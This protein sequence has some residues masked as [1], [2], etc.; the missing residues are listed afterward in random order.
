[1]LFPKYYLLLY[2]PYNIDFGDL[3]DKSSKL[4][5]E[6]NNNK[7]GLVIDVNDVIIMRDKKI[8][9]V[10]CYKSI[11][12]KNDGVAIVKDIRYHNKINYCNFTI[13][14]R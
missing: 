7:V 5:K 1:M 3:Y 11:F 2:S 9:E 12:E 10:Y 8:S 4:I 14:K 13:S 6:V